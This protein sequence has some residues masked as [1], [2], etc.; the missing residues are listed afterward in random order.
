M[1]EI[2][3]GI[4]DLK[5]EFE[6]TAYRNIYTIYQSQ[7]LFDDLCTDSDQIAV[8]QKY[9]NITSGVLHES[10]Q[11]H[12]LFDYSKLHTSSLTGAFDPPYT[13]GRFGDGNGYGVWYSAME[14]KTSIYE[15]FY[16]QW[17]LAK[18]Q[19][20]NNPKTNLITIDRKMFSCELKSNYVLD[21]RSQF[22]LYDNLTSNKYDFCNE[23][24][25]R[26]REMGVQMMIVPSARNIGGLCSPV[27]LPEVI[28]NERA[29]YFL[30]FYFHKSG[31]AEIERI[32]NKKESFHF[33]PNWGTDEPIQTQKEE[34][35]NFN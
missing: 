4:F 28:K 15:A 19:F 23:L 9:E 25:K 10:H 12:R 1:S 2:L 31:K 21:F 30:K 22:A 29:V 24:G 35:N 3:D 17:Q 14:E 27:F 18:E 32:S 13:F 33:P 16:H 34:Q 26:A 6:G 20:K 5:M 8:L 7:D 11:K